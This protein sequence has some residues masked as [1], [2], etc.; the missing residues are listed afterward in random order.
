MLEVTIVT[1]ALSLTTGLCGCSG[2]GS[3]SHDGGN[4]GDISYSDDTDLAFA[5][6]EILLKAMD[7]ADQGEVRNA[8]AKYG[9]VDD[10]NATTGM[11]VVTVDDHLDSTGLEALIDEI[12]ESEPLIERGSINW[13]LPDQTVTPS[14]TPSKAD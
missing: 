6:N 3:S 2:G 9:D 8:L 14:T 4:A 5:N 7:G 1:M 11:Y 12:V 10:S 13:T